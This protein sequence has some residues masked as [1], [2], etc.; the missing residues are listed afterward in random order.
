M[1][2]H[3]LLPLP[4][5]SCFALLMM[6]IYVVSAQPGS[7]QLTSGK[8]VGI[9]KDS[10]G[11]VV[12]KALIKALN[13]ET[14]IARDTVSSD[15][16]TYEI[17]LLPPGQYELSAELAAFKRYVRRPI[18]VEVNQAS[19][20]DVELQIGPLSQTVEVATEAIQ[21][22]STTPTLG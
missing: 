7:A 19:R 6:A 11:A 3:L 13:T 1:F 9:V 18:T 14:K 16:G 8:I 15:A 10:S 22:Q 2:H 21:V 5:Q 20:V 4:Y 17:V 12:P